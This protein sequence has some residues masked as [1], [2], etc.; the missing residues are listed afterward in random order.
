MKIVNKKICDLVIDPE[1]SRFHGARNLNS[2]KESLM[3]FSQYCPIVIQMNSN[4]IIAG[5]GTYQ[6]AKELGWDEIQ[7]VE[8]DV[9][10][11]T[12]TMMSIADNRT[13]ELS[14]WDNNM[15]MKVLTS[16]D[17]FNL[18]KTGFKTDEVEK[19]MD[20]INSDGD[21]DK[22]FEKIKN[23]KKYNCPKCGK[24]FVVAKNE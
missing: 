17:E 21:I 7:C 8:A 10:D 12:A 24:Q 20:A 6:A 22:I 19:M 5:N 9:D 15:L 1:N 2:I 18:K 11:E 13:S 14:T 16:L 23:P 3:S 4:K